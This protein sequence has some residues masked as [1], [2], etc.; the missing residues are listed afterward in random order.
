MCVPSPSPIRV[1]VERTINFFLFKLLDSAVHKHA[2]HLTICQV[3]NFCFSF[4]SILSGFSLSSVECW[5]FRAIHI[6]NFRIV[7]PR[8]R[9]TCHHHFYCLWV[10][11]RHGISRHQMEAM[12][13]NPW[14]WRMDGWR[15]IRFR[16]FVCGQASVSKWFRLLF[17]TL[18]WP[19]RKCVW[20]DAWLCDVFKP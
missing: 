7:F 3:H 18:Q 10:S 6:G 17:C 13:S 9:T 4:S 5:V 1:K 8:G 12:T 15:K 16:R 20:V 14:R 19:K 11:R 2:T